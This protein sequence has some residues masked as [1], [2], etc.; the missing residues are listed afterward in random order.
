MLGGCYEHKDNESVAMHHIFYSIAFL[1]CT[2]CDSLCCSYLCFSKYASV[3]YIYDLGTKKVC[4]GRA[5]ARTG[6]SRTL[7]RQNLTC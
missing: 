7:L 5:R 2:T 4:L 6:D 1:A 3:P